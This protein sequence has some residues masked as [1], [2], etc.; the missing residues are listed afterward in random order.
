MAQ[1]WALWVACQEVSK[2]LV[3]VLKEVPVPVLLELLELELALVLNNQTPLLEWEAWEAWEVAWVA[4][5]VWE[6]W[7][8]P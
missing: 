1:P 5:A 8:P 6:E 3:V 7:T 4:W 2:H